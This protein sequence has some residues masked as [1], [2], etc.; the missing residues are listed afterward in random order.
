MQHTVS[1]QRSTF[2]PD[3]LP[4]NKQQHTRSQA[5]VFTAFALFALSGLMIGFAV[6]A[7]VRAHQAG[8]VETTN[9]GSTNSLAQK[10][11]PQTALPVD[12]LAQG[13][14]G[15][16]SINLSAFVQVADG[17]TSTMVS[18]QAQVRDKSG[19]CLFNV[20]RPLRAPGITCK[21]WLV[22]RIPAGQ[23]L[24]FPKAREQLTHVEMLT[25]PITGTIQH[26]DF[27]EIH[28]LNF[29][30]A[31]PQMQ[32]CNDQGQAKWNYTVLPSVPPGN[33]DLVILTDWQGKSLDWSWIDIQIKKAN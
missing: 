10:K 8:Q 23:I 21:L 14:L 30:A 31:T 7:F 27:P 19:K 1:P 25:G 11:T 4:N 3:N 32:L 12:V 13:G 9:R 33:Y 29:D 15:C 22:Q 17:K 20:D 28:G 5:M 24:E 26:T 2:R 18:T 6:G 16:P